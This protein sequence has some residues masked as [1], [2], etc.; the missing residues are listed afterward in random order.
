LGQRAGVGEDV[1]NR[2]APQFFDQRFDGPLGQH[3]QAVDRLRTGRVVVQN[4]EALGLDAGVDPLQQRIGPHR[5]QTR[6]EFVLEDC[7]FTFMRQ[8]L[9]AVHLDAAHLFKD[10]DE[11]HLVRP[12]LA[13]V[14]RC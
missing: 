6:E 13:S 12:V 8:A 2:A 3:R 5:G 10:L 7:L 4:D 11:R 9:S 1:E 14:D